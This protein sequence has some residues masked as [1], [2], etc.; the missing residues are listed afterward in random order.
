MDLLS[1]PSL[2]G[3]LWKVSLQAGVLAVVILLLSR[4]AGNVPAKYRHALW[5]L[6][7]VK[8]L[9]PPIVHLPA[10]V[11][12]WWTNSAPSLTRMDTAG[13]A[14][15][16]DFTT[17]H[18]RNAQLTDYNLGKASDYQPNRFALVLG[19]VWLIGVAMM[20]LVLLVRWN[21]QL[22]VV[23]AS[24]SADERLTT[25]VL[26]AASGLGVRGVGV[27]LSDSIRTPIL[28]GLLRPT[29]L[30]PVH[31]NDECSR[32]DLEAIIL[33]ELSH[34][35]RRDPVVLWLYQLVQV[36]FFFHPA[37][38]LAG[39]ELKREREMACDEMV[40]S[41]S[42][43]SRSEYAKGYIAALRLASAATFP[44]VLGMAEPFDVERNR[45]ERILRHR[46]RPLTS[47]W[48]VCFAICSAGVVSFAD[49]RPIF[50]DPAALGIAAA[51]ERQEALC[52]QS[53]VVEYQS[54]WAWF[55]AGSAEKQ[56]VTR[57]RYVRTPDVQRL[58]QTRK[59][60]YLQTSYDRRANVSS[61]VVNDNG[62]LIERK[63]R[64]LGM[65]L[66]NQET[67]ETALYHLY[68]GPLCK[69]IRFGTVARQYELV[70]GHKCLR[71]EI[72]SNKATLAKY[73]LWVD[74]EIGYNPRH[75]EFRWKDKRPTVV[76]FS[77]YA[78]I[79]DGAWFPRKQTLEYASRKQGG[80]F[81]VTNAV[82]SIDCG[83][84]IG[85]DRL[86]VRLRKQ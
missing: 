65:L 7:L 66:G 16:T 57:Y 20:L 51:L 80:W 52:G 31:I 34:V 17:T 32:K 21:R 72:P 2:H 55:V 79:A 40:I 19:S 82:S 48:V 54:E 47:G 53:L 46:V 15:S 33:H 12:P 6:V 59:G 64:G 9:I 61:N 24:S 69:R 30:L 27:R 1:S 23:R 81:T 25:T 8:F 11:P 4:L 62:R 10:E 28:V 44:T 75:L 49:V 78:R 38:W 76:T 50:Q 39:R 18:V 58:D 86:L 43:I 45:I 68:E 42:S 70:E 13:N 22:S 3:F 85:M 5:I 63:M 36:I 37:V 84:H 26:D 73:V 67:L 83:R 41:G 35:K 14:N 56:D 71:V 60:W 74:P 77:D 29:I